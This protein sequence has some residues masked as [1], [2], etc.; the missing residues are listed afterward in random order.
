MTRI[1]LIATLDTK[2]E[3]VH[4]VS[5]LLTDEGIEVTLVDVGVQGV[6]TT[7]ASITRHQVAEAAGSTIDA[8]VA[9]N[10]RA[11]ALQ[12][13]AD[14]SAQLVRAA[15]SRGEID[16]V[17]G[18]G[19]SGNTAIATAVMRAIPFGVPK[20]MVSTVASADVRQ[21]V[22]SAD[23]T[24]MYSV[25]DIAGLNR[26][27]RVVLANAAHMIAGASKSAR[28]HDP[29]TDR[30]LI[31]ATMFGVTTACV[32]VARRH[33]E[34]LGYEVLVFHATGTG[35]QS[36]ESLIRSK[37][38]T[39]VLDVTT[40]EIA[41]EIASGLFSA[42]PHRLEAAAASGIP[43]VVS[44]GALDM[45]NFLAPET[46]P[47]HLAKRKLHAHTPHVTLM[48]TSVDENRAI[49]EDIATKLNRARGPVAVFLPLRGVSAMSVP[50]QPFYEP[51]A[52]A[53]L[54]AALKSE[55]A[56]N[57]ELHEIDTDINDPDFARLMAER[58]HQMI[59]D[60]TP[61]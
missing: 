10:D 6:V 50:G 28:P 23:I 18:F 9:G 42:G 36:M 34:Q 5:G 16:G 61:E 57:V 26:V 7:C 48:R 45:A 20:L 39:G 56:P 44:L 40:T 13:M 14:G 3:E 49:G 47:G 58:L 52:D 43:Q 30:P 8:L 32:D 15:H 22:G 12:V 46:V 33:L 21:Y 60:R 4:F 37:E 24:M 59:T 19:G 54:F 2:A 1:A 29:D 53:A 25:A 31:A 17:I 11:A 41:D 38:L 51:D 35:G 55:L 27:T